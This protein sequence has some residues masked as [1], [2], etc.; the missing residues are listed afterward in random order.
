MIRFHAY[1]I[2]TKPEKCYFAQ[3]VHETVIGDFGFADDKGIVGEM[4]EGYRAEKKCKNSRRL[5]GA[6][7]CGQD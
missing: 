3:E 2:L 4:E 5:G 6:G 7:E 1:A